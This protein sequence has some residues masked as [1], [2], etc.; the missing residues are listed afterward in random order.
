[1]KIIT[2]AENLVY[3]H[4]LRAEHGLSLYIDT[5]KSK[6]LFDTGQSGLFIQNA[7]QL[8]LDIADVDILVLSHGHYDHTGGLNDFIEKNSKASILAGESIFLPKYS[9]HNRFISTQTNDSIIRRVSFINSVTKL[10][11]DVFAIPNIKIDYHQDTHFEKFYKEI[12]KSFYPDDFSEELFL[13]VRKNGKISII[14]A[15]SHRGI[16][17]ICNT[18]V[19]YFNLP[20]NLILGGFHMKNSTEEQYKWILKYLKNSKPDMLGVCHCTGVENYARLI[21]DIDKGVFYNY[22]GKEIIFE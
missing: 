19:G 12:S 14:T 3:N 9:G 20:I 15:C 17:N 22:T 13:V 16:T 21:K 8:G 6:I 2:L 18:A 11:E 4:D 10:D 7:G 5:G 1:M